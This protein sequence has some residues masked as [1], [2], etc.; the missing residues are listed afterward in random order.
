MMINVFEMAFLFE[1][2]YTTLVSYSENRGCEKEQEH[3]KCD[4]RCFIHELFSVK[5]LNEQG[6]SEGFGNKQRLNTIPYKA[7][8]IDFGRNHWIYRM[9]EVGSRS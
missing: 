3:R 4:V 9:T 7:F 5:N 8:S 6:T 2:G 1:I